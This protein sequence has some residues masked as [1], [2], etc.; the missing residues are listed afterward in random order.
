MAGSAALTSSAIGAAIF[1]LHWGLDKIRDHP[2]G[3]NRNVFAE[4]ALPWTVVHLVLALM[5]AFAIVLM[6]SASIAMIGRLRQG[7]TLFG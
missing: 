4:L 6:A 7:F 2:T 1:G 3:S 5:L